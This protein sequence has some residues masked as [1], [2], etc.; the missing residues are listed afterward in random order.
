M[1]DDMRTNDAALRRAA[2]SGYPTATDLCR[3]AGAGP[4][5]ALPR[6]PSYC[7]RN[8]QT[9]RETLGLALDKLPLAEMQ[10]IEPGITNDV[11]SVLSLEASLNSRKSFGRHRARSR[12]R[13]DFCFWQEKLS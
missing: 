4:R 8:R 6:G 9:R 13:A 12:A 3:L 5:Q 10:K 1:I 2:E 11:Y 7:G